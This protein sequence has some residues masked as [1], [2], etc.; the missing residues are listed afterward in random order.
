MKHPFLLIKSNTKGFTLIETLIA[1]AVL[2]IALLGAASLLFSVI[3]YNR[4]VEIST[5]GLLMAQNKI[6]ELKSVRFDSI[7]DS[8]EEEAGYS[9]KCSVINNSP[10]QGLKTIE[11][12][13]N[14]QEKGEARNVVLRTI[15][16][17]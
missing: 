7:V 11:V 12:T 4:S 1:M 5:K 6:E 17:K 2:S 10:G 14:W 8:E 9:R 3:H 16:G 15:F 13:V